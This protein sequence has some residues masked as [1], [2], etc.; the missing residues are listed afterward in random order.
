MSL[1]DYLAEDIEIIKICM[2]EIKSISLRDRQG[3]YYATITMERDPEYSHD[4]Y[5]Q[6]LKLQT[7][8]DA[9]FKH[10]GWKTQITSGSTPQMKFTYRLNPDD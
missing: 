8:M 5:R 7:T 9:Q 3:K 4:P 2:P 6:F 1:K 10:R